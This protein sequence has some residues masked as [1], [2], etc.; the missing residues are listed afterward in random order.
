MRRPK[1]YRSVRNPDLF[2]HHTICN[3]PLERKLTKSR[4]ERRDYC[5]TCKKFV[6]KYEE[7]EWRP[8]KVTTNA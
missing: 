6:N 1:L 7:R 3:T 8:L 4:A 5:P 2:M